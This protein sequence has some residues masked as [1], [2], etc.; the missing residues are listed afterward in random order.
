M[1]LIQ[2]RINVDVTLWRA[3]GY[4]SASDSLPYFFRALER[5]KVVFRPFYNGDTPSAFW[6]VVYTKRKEFAQQTNNWREWYTST[7][8]VEQWWKYI[9][10]VQ[11]HVMLQNTLGSSLPFLTRETIFFDSLCVFLHPKTSSEKGSTLVRAIVIWNRF[12]QKW[13][14]RSYR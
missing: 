4:E 13:S 2:C 3:V 8:M 6:N 7:G 5:H 12:Q 9:L 14:D 11:A 10:L 1:K